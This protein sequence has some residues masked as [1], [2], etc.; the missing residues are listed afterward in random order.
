MKRM[1]RFLWLSSTIA[2]LNLAAFGQVP[3]PH[4]DG[5][6]YP[7]TSILGGQ[8]NWVDLNSGD[9]VVVE[10]GSLTYPGF[11]ASTGNRIKFDGAGKDPAKKFDSTATGIVYYS[12]LMKV[13]SL[14]GLDATGGYFAAFYNT[15]TGTTTGAPVWTRLNGT[16]FDIGV[17]ARITAGTQSWS[18]GYSLNTTY[19]IVGAYQFVAGTTND[20][21]KLWI[22]PDASTFGKSEPPPTLTA[23]NTTTDLA[24]VVRF[25]FRQDAANLTPFIEVDELRIGKSWADVTP[26]G[27]TSV[28]EIKNGLVP[29][30]LRLQQNYPNPFNPS[31]TIEFAVASMQSVTVSIHDLLGREVAM[32]VNE[33]LNPGTY[34]AQWN[35]AS[36]PSGIYFYTVRA[37]MESMTRR[38]ILMK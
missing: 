12:F 15:S 10:A 14:G 25:F 11:A 18:S 22:N 28:I 31:T 1:I 16:T 6:D 33:T 13:T 38:M 27:S 19:L 5:F 32:L 34:R 4:Y 9:T 17:S 24:S 23:V 21:A 35:A 3:L 29:R 30:Q 7:A 8:G 20:S 2:L 26:T 37:G 36:N